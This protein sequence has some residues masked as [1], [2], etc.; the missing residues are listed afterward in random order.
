MTDTHTHLYSLEG[1]G[2]GEA[3]VGR[4]LEAGVSRMVFPGIDPESAPALL[5]LAAR[6]PENIRIALGLHPTELGDD[7]QGRLADMQ[8]MYDASG[9]PVAA[10]GEV[11]I[12]LHWDAS[13][14]PAQM[15]AS[16]RQLDMAVERGLPVII[17][18]R[19]AL[20]ETLEAIRG[21]ASRHGGRLPRLVFHSFTGG[22]EDV[23]RIR[24]VC[25]PWFGINGVVTYKNAPAL[26]EALPVIGLDRL[27]LETDSPYL[28]P[29]PHRGRRN[30]SA[31]L[32]H[33]LR[34]AADSLGLPEEVVEEATDRNAAALFFTSEK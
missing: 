27:L 34:T 26:R 2:E 4:A 18:S 14:L 13:T 31:Y 25:D 6:Y 10:I 24:E 19:D 30:E 16:S 33:I 7:W 20:E 21:C 1:S 22:P 9:L 28:A 3:A 8:R 23:R 17:H 15:E 32:T 5:G 12:D 11:G 29:V